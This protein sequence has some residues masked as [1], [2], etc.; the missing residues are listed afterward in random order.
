[1]TEE[2]TQAVE[3]QESTEPAGGQDGQA[4][5]E[6]KDY[7]ALLQKSEEDRKALEAKVRDTQ[8]VS[9]AQIGKLQEL[10]TQA[11]SQQAAPADPE[12]ETV[13]L[14]PSDPDSYVQAAQ[15]VARKEVDASNKVVGG[16]LKT[17]MEDSFKSKREALR[18]ENPELWEEIGSKFDSF[19]KENPN[20]KLR[21]TESVEQVYSYYTGEWMR[22]NP[23]KVSD[24]SRT[25]PAAPQTSDPAPVHKEEPKPEEELDPREEQ[26]AKAYGVSKEAYA[27]NRGD[28][29]A[30]K[31]ESFKE[32]RRL[33]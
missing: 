4:S 20:E 31:K 21:G 19:Y 12:P 15:K 18:A 23:T 27:R 8:T 33:W 2:N 24:L 17:V 29:K 26:L 1:M 10:V 13:E 9:E 32:E 3:P 16:V 22:T 7:Q 14:D 25:A 28:R 5:P 11:F 6:D 30:A